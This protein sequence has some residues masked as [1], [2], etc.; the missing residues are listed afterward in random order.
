[1][2]PRAPTAPVAPTVLMFFQFRTLP[3]TA[4]FDAAENVQPEV[5]VVPVAFTVRS[6]WLDVAPTSRSFPLSPLVALPRISVT[7]LA[8]TPLRSRPSS[9]L[10][11]TCQS[12]SVLPFAD[13]VLVTLLVKLWKVTPP[14]FHVEVWVMK[15]LV[16]VMVPCVRV[17]WLPTP[18]SVRPP[19]PL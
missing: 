11:F 12:K 13:A 9:V 15:G 6:H 1:M 19:V 4:K 10:P 2:M 7:V 8:A 16:V 3:V 14:A 17:S 18:F 5:I